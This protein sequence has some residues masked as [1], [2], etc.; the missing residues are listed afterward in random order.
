M[1]KQGRDST[2]DQELDSTGHSSGSPKGLFGAL[3]ASVRRQRMAVVVVQ[4][5]QDQLY[6]LCGVQ[7]GARFEKDHSEV[8][9]T[10]TCAKLFD[11]IPTPISPITWPRDR[12]GSG[13]ISGI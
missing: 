9:D 12:N 6:E 13:I 3:C 11:G 7:E 4:V 8:E 1:Q 10:I 2:R 5:E